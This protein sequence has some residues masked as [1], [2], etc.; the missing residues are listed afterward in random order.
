MVHKSAIFGTI[1]AHEYV[2]IQS[3]DQCGNEICPGGQKDGDKLIFN[4]GTGTWTPFFDEEVR[5]LAEL[6]FQAEEDAKVILG[7]GSAD[8]LYLDRDYLAAHLLEILGA[9]RLANAG[10]KQA[11]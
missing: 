5:G 7:D 10:W 4:E 9:A 11:E 8:P 6:K 2:Q 3:S 1:A